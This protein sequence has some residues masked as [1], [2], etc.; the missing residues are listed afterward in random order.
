MPIAFSHLLCRVSDP[1]VNNRLANASHRTERNK[2]MTQDVETLHHFPPAIGDR[3]FP[4]QINL[5]LC[6]CLAIAGR[7][8]SH[9]I[10][11]V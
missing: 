5:L 11:V 6:E 10:V 3:A 9:P 4:E 8:Q 2:R 1:S 7:K